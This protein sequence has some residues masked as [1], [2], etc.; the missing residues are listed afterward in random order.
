[1]QDSTANMR[2]KMYEILDIQNSVLAGIFVWRWDFT[3]LKKRQITC[4]TPFTYSKE[5]KIKRNVSHC[6]SRHPVSLPHRKDGLGGGG[7]GA[8]PLIFCF[9]CLKHAPMTNGPSFQILWQSFKK[10]LFQFLK[11]SGLAQPLHLKTRFLKIAPHVFV[12]FFSH[13]NSLRSF[14]SNETECSKTC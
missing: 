14:L 8:L 5:L 7:E 3:F 10:E 12:N 13:L 4:Y 6:L 9:Y 2:K 11:I 1:M